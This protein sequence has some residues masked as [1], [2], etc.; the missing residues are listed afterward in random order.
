[1]SASVT[2]NKAA[3]MRDL[4]PGH[5]ACP[6]CGSNEWKSAKL[7]AL[8][9]TTFSEGEIRGTI[10]SPGQFSGSLR[11]FLLSDFWFSRDYP[12]KAELG[13]KSRTALVD[14]VKQFT[15]ESWSKL[16]KP[17]KPHT[18]RLR[19]FDRLDPAKPEKPL[20]PIPPREPA[21]KLRR[22]HFLSSLGKSIGLSLLGLIPIVIFLPYIT[23]LYIT[24]AVLVSVVA[25]LIGA[26]K[27]NERQSADYEKAVEDFPKSLEAYEKAKL[28]FPEELKNYNDELKK[29]RQ[30][31]IQH[32]QA[33]EEHKA[34]IKT[35]HTKLKELELAKEFLWEHGRICTRCGLAYLGTY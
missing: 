6:K 30:N 12:L 21:P 27:G 25:G 22:H 7:T 9:G 2:A 3:I 8:E 34:A 32:E 14:E 16:E 17:Q 13:L 10:R 15:F 26:L 18:P 24:C 28:D 5:Q 31:R 23:F 19:F 11:A 20:K 35:Y 1:V 29:R 4:G 33:L